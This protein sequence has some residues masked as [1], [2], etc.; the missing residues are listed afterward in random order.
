VGI[1]DS[2]MFGWG[3]AWSDTF[4]ARIADRYAR[5]HGGRGV[6]I[7]NLGVPGYNTWQE[8]EVFAAKAL[9]LAPDAVVLL[10]DQN[11]AGLANFIRAPRSPWTL[12]RSYLVDFL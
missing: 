10:A 1:G 3:V 12:E 2:H 6:A 4:L 11:D 7:T 8:A 9:A 5:E